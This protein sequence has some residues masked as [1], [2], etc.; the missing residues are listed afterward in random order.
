MYTCRG[1]GRSRTGGGRTVRFSRHQHQHQLQ[2]QRAAGTSAWHRPEHRFEHQP[3]AVIATWHRPLTIV[4]AAVCA[5]GDEPGRSTTLTL[6]VSLF[7][8]R[9]KVTLT[10][11]GAFSRAACPNCLT[12]CGVRVVR[13]R[14]S[15]LHTL[16]FSLAQTHAHAAVCSASRVNCFFF[17][18]SACVYDDQSRR[19]Q[20]RL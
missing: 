4:P 7:S 16:S 2:H 1:V 18:A 3:K 19:L 14:L 20:E 17:P 6:C 13:F 12:H 5:R 11:T 10:L 8:S 15:L 9:L